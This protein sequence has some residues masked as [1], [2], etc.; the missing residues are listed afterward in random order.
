MPF[1]GFFYVICMLERRHFVCY[2]DPVNVSNVACPPVSGFSP[3]PLDMKSG[4]SPSPHRARR[5]SK[6]YETETGKLSEQC[7]SPSTY[8]PP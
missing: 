7:M 3:G 4:N 5:P 1:C 2:F 8:G 6:R